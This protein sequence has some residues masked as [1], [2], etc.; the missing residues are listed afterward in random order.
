[1]SRGAESVVEALQDDPELDDLLE[2]ATKEIESLKFF[3]G[4]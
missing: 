3:R 4:V 2:K 1:M